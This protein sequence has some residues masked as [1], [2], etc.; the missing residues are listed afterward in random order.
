[1]H[2]IISKINTKFENKYFFLKLY[3][4]TYNKSKKTCCITFLYP[5]DKFLDDAEK[6]EIENF[7]VSLLNLNA[8]TSVKFKKSYLDENLITNAFFNFIDKSFPS[9]KGF[10]DKKSA[11]VEKNFQQRIINIKID[12]EFLSYISEDK[13]KN[14]TKKELEKHFIT[15]IY[16]NL[17]KAKIAKEVKFIP[18]ETVKKVTPRYEVK[19]GRNLFGGEIVPNPEFIKN[20]KGEK[21]S[22]ILA[23]KIENFEKKSYEVKKGKRAGQTKNYFAFTLYDTTARIDVRYF[24]TLANEKHMDQLAS[25]DE[26]IILGN[27]E[28]FN[29]KLTLYVSA[30]SRCYLPEKIEI[31]QE[32]SNNFE[33]V[34]IEPYS[35]V[36][37][38]NLFK[39]TIV[40]NP[41]IEKGKF[42]V[43]D[44]ETTG[45]N[46]ET[47]ELL[48]I[49][50]VK[51][52]NGKIVSK[53]QTLIK[54]KK[55]IP[56]SATAINNITDV[57]VADAPKLDAVIRD[58]YR[59][60]KDCGMVG[61]N[62][63][64]DQK[65]V[66]Q[67]GKA[68]GIVF[69]NEFIDLMPIAKSKLRLS[70]YKLTDVVKRL[71]ITLDNAHRA[72]ADALATAE[73][74]LKLNSEEYA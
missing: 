31:K 53:F 66:V 44:V 74:F 6:T 37:Q 68:Q 41:F 51:I 17:E 49:G 47:D 32:F 18:K 35:I 43:F 42:V 2:W 45:L 30:I 70:R 8:K 25:G 33:V 65:F 11:F 59:Y 27:V 14:E 36:S 13:L 29:K 22:I 39:T 69:E 54:P 9:L 56:P 50:A 72:Y 3:S 61:Y 71:E 10:I 20:V 7:I 73:A 63:S 60:C 24:T 16:L 38:E 64:F 58:F 52:E 48:E 5:E 4:V 19:L 21:T 55:P 34:K 40:Y 1:M 15:E 12:E 23:G 46:Y 62:V 57:M 28:E 26:V 67:A